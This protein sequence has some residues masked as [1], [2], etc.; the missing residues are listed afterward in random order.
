[1]LNKVKIE[2]IVLNHL[3]GSDKFLVDIEISSTNVIDVYVDGDN[4]I[5]IGE[6]VQISRLIESAFDRDEED[7]ELRV[8]SPGLDS[9]FKL[10]RQYK[11]YVGREIRISLNDGQKLKATLLT[12]DDDGIKAEYKADKKAKTK[13]QA[14][15]KF[16]EI[17]TVKPE[18]SF[19]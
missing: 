11:K 19:K 9:P 12:V 18:I 2:E 15:F 10:L 13:T 7:Y 8:S 1:M 17:K 14:D 4:G 6:C 16:E 3:E 5:S